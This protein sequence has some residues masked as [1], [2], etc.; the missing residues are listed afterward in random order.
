MKS[1]RMYSVLGANSH[2]HMEGLVEINESQKKPRE[3]SVAAETVN[4]T[5]FCS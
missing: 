1:N 3:G 4:V 5:I 2:T